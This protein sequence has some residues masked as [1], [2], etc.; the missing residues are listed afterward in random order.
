MM[1]DRVLVGGRSLVEA[2]AE[3]RLLP[4]R[5]QYGVVGFVDAGG[6]GAELD[7]FADGVS[8]AAGFGARVRLWYVPLSLDLAYRIV[9]RDDV[10]AAWDR[11]LAFVRV[12]EAF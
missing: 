1:C 5:K 7:P 10:D 12:G 2:S 4:W 9:D 3:L 11:I 6:A 8:M